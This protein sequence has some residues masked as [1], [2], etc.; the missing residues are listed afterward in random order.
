M[1][2]MFQPIMYFLLSVRIF[3]VMEE[4]L[5]K[6]FSFDTVK[7]IFVLGLVDGVMNAIQNIE[8]IDVD[9]LAEAYQLYI[10]QNIFTP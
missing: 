5:K 7:K 1:H 4:L 10:L 9:N 2:I 6:D 3:T 8:V